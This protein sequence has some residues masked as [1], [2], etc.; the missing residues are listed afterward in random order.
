LAGERRASC[1]EPLRIPRVAPAKLDDWPFC[2]PREFAVT[3]VSSTD[4]AARLVDADADAAKLWLVLAL[5][6]AGLGSLARH[7]TARVG[8]IDGAR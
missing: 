3:V 6:E 8:V 7:V 2:Q 5:R 1:G 4:S